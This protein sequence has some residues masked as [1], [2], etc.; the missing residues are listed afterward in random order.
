MTLEKK[1]VEEAINVF[2]ICCTLERNNLD[3]S[4][5]ELEGISDSRLVEADRQFLINLAKANREYVN[6]AEMIIKHLVSLKPDSTTFLVFMSLHSTRITLNANTY[7]AMIDV[8][9]DVRSRK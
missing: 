9:S 3:K 5:K 7:N 6:T 2:F 8:I 1:Q 4:I